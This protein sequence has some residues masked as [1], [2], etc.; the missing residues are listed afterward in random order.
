MFKIKIRGE[1]NNFME[2]FKIKNARFCL[3]FG[4]VSILLISVFPFVFLTISAFND[5][6]KIISFLVLSAFSLFLLIK[7][8]PVLLLSQIVL[9]TI[10]CENKARTKFE[11]PENFNIKDLEK[12]ISK[13]GKSY[14]PV[15]VFPQPEILKYK[16]KNPVSIYSKGIETIVS[17]YTTEILTEDNYKSIIKSANKNIKNLSGKKK[18]LFLDSQQKKSPLKITNVIFIFAN[19]VDESIEERLFEMLSNTDKDGFDNSILPCV[20]NFKK[21]EVI[22]NSVALPN[23]FSLN[24]ARNRGIRLIRKKFFR[25]KLKLKNNNFVKS[26]FNDKSFN[27]EQTLWQLLKSEFD[28]IVL[29]ERKNKQI[30]KKL[31]D[32]Q[33]VFKDDF[34]YIKYGERGVS[35][36]TELNEETQIATIDSFDMWDYPKAN[37]ISKNTIAVIK[38]LAISYFAS[39]GYTVKF[40]KFEDED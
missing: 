21:S 7:L 28:E 1:C 16:F 34:L 9:V 39:Q 30:F 20:V 6:F 26:I 32:K 2:I 17:T 35:L 14:E 33:V 31:S 15:T 3:I 12:R 10:D 8:L 38:N 23:V 24:L 29:I 5:I 36:L 19:C 37:Q 27:R 11:L 40:E 22:F 25:N 4:S 18:A 13:Y